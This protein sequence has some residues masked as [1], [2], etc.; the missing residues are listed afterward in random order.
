MP[1]QRPGSGQKTLTERGESSVGPLGWPGVVWRASWMAERYQ[2]ALP[3]RRE[4]LG[5]PP[6]RLGVVGR[7]SWR[8]RS[9]WEALP[10]GCE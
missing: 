1:S 3:E 5:V 6:V 8:D 4:W 10:E 9:G 7:H 2:E